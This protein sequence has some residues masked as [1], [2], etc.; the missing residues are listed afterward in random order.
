MIKWK[1]IFAVL[2]FVLAGCGAGQGEDTAVSPD[3]PPEPTP[4]PKLRY[5]GSKPEPGTGNVY[6]QVLWNSAAATGLDV[7]LCQD[8]SSFSGCGGKEYTTQTNESGVYLFANIKPGT[9]AITTRIFDSDDWIYVSGGILSA[10]DFQVKADKTLVIDTQHI[11]KLNMRPLEPGAQ[12]KV[13]SGSQT[14]NW[15][16]DTDAAYYEIYLTPDKGD[17]I[18]VNKRANEAQITAELPPIN[19]DYRWSL[20][21]FNGDD[22]KIAE[23]KDYVEFQVTGEKASCT[24]TVNKPA[25]GTSVPAEGIVLDWDGAKLAVSYKILMWDDTDTNPD[26]TNTL[27]FVAVSESQFTF[28]GALI[29][30]H[31]YVWSVHAY[32]AAGKKIAASEIYDFTVIAD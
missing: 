15:E 22:V 2:L 10:A 7:V 29:P 28:N 13:K 20:E 23:T 16:A 14:F 24:L 19:C 9:Y 17:P 26:K 3:N 5:E 30:D 12:A 11:Y 32:D 25:D 1:L 31:R 8:F 21:A 18:F 6:G 27:D 4:I